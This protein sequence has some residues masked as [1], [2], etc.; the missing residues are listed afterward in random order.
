MTPMTPMLQLGTKKDNT[1]LYIVLGIVGVLIVGLAVVVVILMTSGSKE[2]LQQA[3]DV[4]AVKTTDDLG[5]TPP[6]VAQHAP[7]QPANTAEPA[8]Q[9]L[10]PVVNDQEAPKTQDGDSQAPAADTQ[11]PKVEPTP[12]PTPEPTTT[13]TTGTT[14]TKTTGTTTTKTT[15]TTTTKTTETKPVETKP[16]ETKPAAASD[17]LSKNEVQSVIRSSFGDVRTCS[18]MSDQK[19][20]MNVSFVIKGNGRV[21]NARVTSPEFANSPAA[22]CVLK[23]V[24][25]LKFRETGAADVPI[26]YPFSI[27]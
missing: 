14:T 6:T 26:T 8:G 27:Q 13:K 10:N 9:G 1:A 18:R 19:G 2:E 12:T 4:N 3:V 22:S 25:G 7:A 21:S 20:T 5:I 23:V 17:S 24:N 15:G 16:V 11:E